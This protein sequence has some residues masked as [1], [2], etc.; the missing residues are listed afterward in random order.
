VSLGQ[1]PDSSW[2]RRPG[3][4]RGRWLDQIRRDTG[5]D[6]SITGDRHKGEAIGVEKGRYGPRWLRDDD[7][8]DDDDTQSLKP[9]TAYNTLR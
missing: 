7:D 8:D 5:H 9:R 1:P 3:R 4:P 6:S 2:R